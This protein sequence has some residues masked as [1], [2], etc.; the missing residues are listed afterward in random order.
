MLGKPIK[1]QNSVK[2]VAAIL[3]QRHHLN[4]PLHM[5]ATKPF[6]IKVIGA[7]D[8]FDQNGKSVRPTGRKDSAILAMLALTRN[9]RQTRTWLQDKLW[10]DRGP[11]QGAASLRQALTTIR[12]ILN[13]DEEIIHSDRT[14]VWLDPDQIDFDHDDR[15]LFGEILRGFDLKEEGFNEWLRETKSSYEA[16]KTGWSMLDAREQPDRR[17]HLDIAPVRT[18]E[19]NLSDIGEAMTD[20]LT[21]ALSVVGVHAMIDRREAPEAPDPRATDIVVTT[22]V[23]SFGGGCLLSLRAT[24][25]FGSL[26]WQV[27]R[28]TDAHDWSSLRA[29]QIELTQ[30]FEDFVIRTEAGSLIGARWSAHS[31]GCQAL[32]GILAP[33]TIPLRE[34][35]QCS[36]AAIAA[37]EKGIYHALLGFS[38]L[39]LFGEREMLKDLD[40]D[41]VMQSFRTAM[42][43]S[44][45]NG[46][47]HALAGHSY[48]FILHDLERN[49]EMTEEAVRLLPNSG[50]CQIFHAISSVY[51]TDYEKAVHAACKAVSLCRGTLAQP[52]ARSS[53]LFAKLMAGDNDGAIRAGEMSLEAILFRPTIVD[54][55]TAYARAGRFKDGRKKLRLLVNREPNLST[56]LI[57]SSDYPIVNAEH[58]DAI[59]TAAKQLGLN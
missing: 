55:M 4:D 3:T 48:G 7:F 24:D 49:K 35:A 9:H 31:N 47:V 1:R 28:E 17:W 58:R 23:V 30:L 32:M 50:A 59:V 2:N 33:G 5:S 56:D 25:G 40:A 8:L 36:E 34:I 41:V 38:Q 21:E 39:L 53:E 37:N 57:R 22:R 45:E 27:R 6:S 44:P 54:L 11:A 29:V 20:S 15:G 52:M 42:R 43:L 19:D 10:G 51:T 16:K 18:G 12:A 46:L 14:W 13:T 26:R